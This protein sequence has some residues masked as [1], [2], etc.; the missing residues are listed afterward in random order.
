MNQ[1]ICDRCGN[2]I[3]TYNNNHRVVLYEQGEF[4]TIEFDGNCN[5]RS[6]DLCDNCLD[7]L[8]RINEV[9][10]DYE[11]TNDEIRESLEC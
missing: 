8:N 2:V 6:C 1:Y 3:H 11:K 7:I 9:F 5:F 10:I 4:G